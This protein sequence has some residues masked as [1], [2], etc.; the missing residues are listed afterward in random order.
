MSAL[1]QIEEH[2]AVGHE[3]GGFFGLRSVVL[4]V[5]SE[6]I[7]HQQQA[8]S[9][10]AGKLFDQRS[11]FGQRGLIHVFGMSD[12][13]SE[14]HERITGSPIGD[15]GIKNLV[16]DVANE[17]R[18]D[19]FL[20]LRELQTRIVGSRSRKLTFPALVALFVLE[21]HVDSESKLHLRGESVG[22]NAL[23]ELVVAHDLTAQVHISP[24]FDDRQTRLV[25]VSVLQFVVE[26]RFHRCPSVGRAVGHAVDLNRFDQ[27]VIDVRTGEAVADAGHC[28][29]Q[30]AAAREREGDEAIRSQAAIQTLPNVMQAL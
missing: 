11:Q 25:G 8:R 29:Q 17:F 10:H 5:E 21:A 7:F 3:H 1:C 16:G 26:H 6:G 14:I 30:D 27:I 2:F 28:E 4:V 20:H 18:H 19:A 9:L 24:A 13:R 23:V 22:G 12:E 15:C